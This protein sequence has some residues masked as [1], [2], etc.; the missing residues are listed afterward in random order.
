MK[1][2][3]S[4]LLISLF[5]FHSVGSS[6][7]LVMLQAQVRSE[8]KRRIKEGLPPDQ[9]HQLSF[10]PEEVAVLDWKEQGR[11]FRYQGMMYDVVRVQRQADLL[12]YHCVT[13]TEEHDLFEALDE[14]V[15]DYMTRSTKQKNLKQLVKNLAKAYQTT[16]IAYPLHFLADATPAAFFYQFSLSVIWQDIPVPPPKLA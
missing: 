9:L 12:L 15:Q 3:L 2:L 8:V 10:T 6:L 14:L 1:R 7:V 4:F 16:R 5:L 11:E 13:D